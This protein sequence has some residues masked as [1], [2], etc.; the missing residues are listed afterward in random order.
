[1]CYRIAS[2]KSSVVFNI[3][4]SAIQDYIASP[5]QSL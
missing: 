3:I 2:T 5:V 4:I 1:M